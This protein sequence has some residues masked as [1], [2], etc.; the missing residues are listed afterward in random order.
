MGETVKD[1]PGRSREWSVPTDAKDRPA[2]GLVAPDLD[3]GT[4]A[5]AVVDAVRHDYFVIALVSGSTNPEFRALCD[6]LDVSV[7]EFDPAETDSPWLPAETVARAF[8]FPGV[9]YF[10]TADARIDFGRCEEVLGTANQFSVHAPVVR[11]G[12][13]TDV[14]TMAAIPAYNEGETIADVVAE[15][16][17]YVDEVVVVDDGSDDDTVE[18]AERAGATIVEH[19]TNRG[20]GAALQTVFATATRRNVEQL[21]TLDGDGQH[22]PGDIPKLLQAHSDSGAN[23]V[24]GSR[25]E[26]DVELHVPIYRRFG[27]LLINFLT[28]LSFGVVR[29]K[30]WVSDTQSGFR[31][32]DKEAI[33][34]LATDD[35][36]GDGMSASTDIL[37]H[38]NHRSYAIEEVGTTIRYDGNNTSTRNPLLHGA[39]LVGNIV[40]TVERERPLLSFGV[41]GLFTLFI[42]IGIGYWTLL[43]YLQSQT[44]PAGLA[45]L[46]ILC[47]LLGT[48]L[49]L[50]G[51][52]LHSL[53]AHIEVLSKRTSG[54]WQ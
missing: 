46:C 3:F 27:L 39:V 12:E 6:E 14:A 13:S 4:F 26:D 52:V 25:F 38:A 28:N 24:I 22:E 40:R 32:F 41:P 54:R 43:N 11:K 1:A 8:G 49:T 37:Y 21:V 30:S 44:F 36:I 16:K 53:N 20:Y 10:T 42:G 9:L 29:P 2:I 23:V 47:S 33:R 18:Q 15:A 31:V 7:L 51:V 45:L 34:S 48:F 35:S 19:E 17:Q 50:V 5:R